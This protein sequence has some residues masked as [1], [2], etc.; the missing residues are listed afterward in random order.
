MVVL[1]RAGVAKEVGD[2]AELIAEFERRC[3][4]YAGQRVGFDADGVLW[5]LV[6]LPDVTEFEVSASR[7]GH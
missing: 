2:P 3:P 5:Q 1:K 6:W 4:H 7:A